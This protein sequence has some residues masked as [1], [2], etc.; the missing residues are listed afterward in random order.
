VQNNPT[1]IEK[2]AGGIVYKRVA[3]SI[4]WLIVKHKGALHWGFPKGH[5]GDKNSNEA[6]EEAA[7][8]EVQ[9]EGGITAKIV[10]A[11]SVQTSY[12]FRRGQT[13]HKKTVDYFLMEYISG[14]T[15]N[16]DHEVSAAKFLDE[17]TLLET[18]TFDTDRKA[19]K[20]LKNFLP[21]SSIQNQ[22][23]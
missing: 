12:F 6:I 22:I 19:F 8:R 11:D 21:V 10:H 1:V 5:I 2:S 20:K 9:E 23:L 15:K 7:I 3:S 14:D 13:L 4:S 18:L 17:E 16:H